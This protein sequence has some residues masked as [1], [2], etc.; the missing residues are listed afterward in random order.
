[1]DERFAPLVSRAPRSSS[2]CLAPAWLGT[3]SPPPARAGR[4]YR[5]HLRRPGDGAVRRAEEAD[6]VDRVKEVAPL[7]VDD[8]GDDGLALVRR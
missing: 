4:R 2:W 7:R 3:R 1:M 8:D 6:N 5:V